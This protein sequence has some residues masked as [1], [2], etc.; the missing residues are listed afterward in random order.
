M[1]Q[2]ED[3][4]ADDE[5]QDQQ[6]EPSKVREPEPQLHFEADATQIRQVILNL[7]V[8]AAEAIGDADGVV[9]VATGLRHVDAAFLATAYLAMDLAPGDY[10]ALEVSDTGCGM[11]QATIDRI[12]EPFFTTKAKGSGLGLSI[13]HAI[14][15]QH[16]GRIRVTDSPEGG[17]RFA[18]SLPRAR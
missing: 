18:M 2:T 9:V 16:G 14:V 5:Q 13:V 11:D 10:V 4:D 17:A 8:N 6:R 12:F 15:T 3:Y 1:E 7:V